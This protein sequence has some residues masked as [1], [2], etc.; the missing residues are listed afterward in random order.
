MARNAYASRT[1]RS[2]FR[3]SLKAGIIILRSSS[4]ACG[5]SICGN[6]IPYMQ[7]NRSRIE[8]IGDDPTSLELSLVFQTG[9]TVTI[10]E[11]S[12]LMPITRAIQHQESASACPHDF[13]AE[14]T[15][16]I[17]HIVIKLFN[18]REGNGSGEG[19][20]RQPM[21]MHQ[22]PELIEIL[23]ANSRTDFPPNL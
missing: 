5:S 15:E 11:F 12:Q 19:F 7:I 8:H 18:C 17:A 4:S 10:H 3:D 13:S 16:L 9:H 20:F 1:S 14:N 21:F 23:R 22:V 2:I 6:S